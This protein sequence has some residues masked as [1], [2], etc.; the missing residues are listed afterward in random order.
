MSYTRRYHDS[1]TVSG[2]KTVSYPKSDSG[3]S[4][5]ISYSETVPLDITINV[6]TEPFDN[7]VANTNRSIDVLTGAVVAMN[8]AQCAAIK[9]TAEEVSAHIIDGFF[10]TIKTELSQQIQALDSAIKAGFGLIAEQGKAVSAQKNVMEN[11]YNRISSRYVTLFKDLDNECYK[12][13]Y[14]LDKQSFS[15][16]QKVQ[17]TLLCET[18]S[19]EAAKSLLTILEEASSKTMIAVSG[20][21]RKTQEILRTL[22]NYITQETKI[23]GLIDSFLYDD[24]V[25]NKN[26]LFVPVIFSESSGLTDKGNIQDCA[27][28]DFISSDGKSKIAKQVLDFGANTAWDDIH[29]DEN[30]LLDREL[31][32][33]CES[34]FTEGSEIQNRVYKT[35]IELWHK[36]KLQAINERGYK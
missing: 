16:S 11:D 29:E 4:H 33:R 19:N 26:D 7:S 24:S 13:I 9:K 17:R 8:A 28:P 6:L 2:S 30:L 22:Q 25:N 18:G 12:R 34:Y 23:A 3:G 15:L 21:N 32:S 35:M 31:N 36:S 1:I 20:I 5:T 10:G 27:M 14:A